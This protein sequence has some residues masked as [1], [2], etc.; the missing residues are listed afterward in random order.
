MLSTACTGSALQ[1]QSEKFKREVRDTHASVHQQDSKHHRAPHIQYNYTNMHVQLPLKA[2][3]SSC[4]ARHVEVCWPHASDEI[5]TS[6]WSHSWGPLLMLWS[7]DSPQSLL[8]FRAIA[9][10]HDVKLWHAFISRFGHD[11]DNNVN[12]KVFRMVRPIEKQQTCNFRRT[13]FSLS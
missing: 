12:V 4:W 6:V 9:S 8:P 1:G 10:L 7:A 13:R 2:R 11:I 5:S 3:T